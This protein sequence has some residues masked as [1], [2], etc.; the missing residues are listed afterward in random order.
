MVVSFQKEIDKILH[1]DQHW[2]EKA[3]QLRQLLEKEWQAGHI[4]A[5]ADFDGTLI[6]ERPLVDVTRQAIKGIFINTCH[7]FLHFDFKITMIGRKVIRL[8]TG[9]L[10][11]IVRGN[12]Q[13][14]FTML[15]NH[16]PDEINQYIK[17]V[18]N[19]AVFYSDILKQL[20]GKKLVIISRNDRKLINQTLIKNS[21]LIERYQIK[22]SG[23]IANELLFHQDNQG[24]SRCYG[25]RSP[26]ITTNFKS[27]IIPQSFPYRV[28]GKEEKTLN[29]NFI[30]NEQ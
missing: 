7:D 17:A 15:A 8:I 11:M 19:K 1:S 4:D 28:K 29:S 25:V 27:F 20:S 23:I 2:R 30:A 10:A 21:D 16:S 22:I 12:P 3:S 5:G 18:S 13:I 26:I 9:L 14:F 24:T 6:N